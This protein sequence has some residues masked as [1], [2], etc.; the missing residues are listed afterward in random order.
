[1]KR[2]ILKIPKEDCIGLKLGTL[3]FSPNR[4][5]NEATETD[6]KKIK[7]TKSKIKQKQTNKR[8]KKPPPQTKPSKKT[9]KH[10]A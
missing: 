4:Q 3:K 10:K 5:R 7:K 6:K 2:R 1:M 9:S 8:T